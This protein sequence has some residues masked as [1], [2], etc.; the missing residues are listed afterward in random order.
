[1]KSTVKERI[2]LILKEN[3]L[4]DSDFCRILQVSQGYISGMRKSIQPDKLKSIAI[5][6]PTWNIGWILT[7]E[8]EKYLSISPEDYVPRYNPNL[9]QHYTTAGGLI[10]ILNDMG[11]NFS[12]QE[13]SNDIKER[14]LK[15][16]DEIK[17]SEFIEDKKQKKSAIDI[18]KWI[19]FFV[20]DEKRGVRQPKMYDLYADF[21]K[22]GCI[23]FIKENLKSLNE[24][25]SIEFCE[26]E[27]DASFLKQQATVK[28]ELKHKYYQWR[29][30][31]EC[32][33]IYQGDSKNIN[34]D[35]DCIER[36]YLGCEFFDDIVKVGELC[37]IIE[38]KNIP[39]Q[40]IIQINVAGIGFLS[41][42][43][44]NNSPGITNTGIQVT[45]LLPYLSPQYRRQY[46]INDNQEYRIINYREEKYYKNKYFELLESVDKL[47]DKVIKLQEKENELTTELRELEK[48]NGAGEDSD[49]S[50]AKTPTATV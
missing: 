20:K 32:R 15:F 9:L 50:G 33:I 38:K 1:M 47:K 2:K 4:K 37:E 7:G 40:K 5:N 21:H 12:K 29:D 16:H 17:N 48:K 3:S 39:I 34:I 25:L 42:V 13:K 8:G 43:S 24:N 31:K 18:Y 27:Y 6:Y 11:L 45:K 35:I 26:V 19:S 41:G 28:E 10:G 23:E 44:D 49:A 30:E 36:I 46:D 22:G 14:R